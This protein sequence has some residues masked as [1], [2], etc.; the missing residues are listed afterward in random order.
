MKFY[1]EFSNHY[2]HIFP[3][4][5]A[6]LKF[7]EKKIGDI[8]NH[9][10]AILDV[11]SATGGYSQELAQK[12]YSVTGI[13]LS[14]EMI[15]IAK[16]KAG[17][18]AE[19]YVADMKELERFYGQYDALLCLGNTLPHLTTEE[20]VVKALEEFYQVLGTVG[21]AIIQLVNYDRILKHRIDRLDTIEGE[22]ASLVRKYS[23][24][25][26]GLIDFN[27]VLKLNNGEEFNNTVPLNPIVR[28]DLTK[29]LKSAGFKNVN[30]YGNFAGGAHNDEAH[31]TIVV[32]KKLP[33]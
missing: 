20:E 2:D 11:G 19:F 25:D 3:P 33:K 10:V 17:D 7:V 24:R 5:S 8:F 6:Q 13:D 1:K 28:E 30:Y 22:Q 26:D 23:Y 4:G 31:A 29:Y 16:E 12:G 18:I 21:I 15:D 9:K 14:E 27:T 32:A